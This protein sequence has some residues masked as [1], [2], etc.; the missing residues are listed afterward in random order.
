[1]EPTFR[2]AGPSDT[3][4]LIPFMRDYYAYD[5]HPWDEPRAREAILGLL[6]NPQYG[7]A[8][9]ILDDHKPVG[10][11]VLTFGYSIEFLGRD[12]FIDEFFLLP[13][14]RG[15]GWGRKTLSYVEAQ[16]QVHE[17]RAIHLEVVRQNENAK[18]LYYKT[19]YEDRDH[20]LMSKRISNRPG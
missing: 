5:S 13:S 14:Y 10:Y 2:I 16:A 19:G 3:D 15:R 8:W 11:V 4:F 9:L 1:M 7:I 18:R 12:A 17:I 20:Y 6:R